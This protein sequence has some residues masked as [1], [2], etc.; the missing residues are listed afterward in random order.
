MTHHHRSGATGAT[1]TMTL[2]RAAPTA[3]AAAPMVTATIPVGASPYGVAISLL[4]GDVYVA[5]YGSSTVSV[6]QRPDQ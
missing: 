3:A 1:G 6:I 2:D 4:T 5:N